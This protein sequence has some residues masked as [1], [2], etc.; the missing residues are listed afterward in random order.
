MSSTPHQPSDRLTKLVVVAAIAAVIAILIGAQDRT[1]RAIRSLPEAERH[2][3]YQRTFDTLRSTCKVDASNLDEY[4]REQASL[5]EQFPEC[6]RDC[7]T[8][9]S[10]YLSHPTR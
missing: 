5:I 3:L 6:D 2:A 8:V 9:A 7:R 1:G 4:C 10:P